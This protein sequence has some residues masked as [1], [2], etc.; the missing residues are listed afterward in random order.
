MEYSTPPPCSHSSEESN[1]PKNTQ[2]CCF[3]FGKGDAHTNQ[4]FDVQSK[5]LPVSHWL[6]M[7][8]PAAAG[9]WSALSHTVL[10][11]AGYCLPLQLPVPIAGVLGSLCFSKSGQSLCQVWAHLYGKGKLRSANQGR[12]GAAVSLPAQAKQLISAPLLIPTILLGLTS[13]SPWLHRRAFSS[14]L[15]TAVNPLGRQD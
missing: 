13:P 9:P 5:Q 8:Q 14:S 2:Q 15:K 7:C 3:T 6:H 10:R 11:D 4:P 12:H 1:G